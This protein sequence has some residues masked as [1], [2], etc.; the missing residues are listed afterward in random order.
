MRLVR[1]PGVKEWESSL[2][3]TQSFPGRAVALDRR[4]MGIVTRQSL[5]VS[6][7]SIK[8]ALGTISVFFRCK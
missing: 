5:V 6:S 8:A 3:H 4:Q 1:S 2:P 7:S